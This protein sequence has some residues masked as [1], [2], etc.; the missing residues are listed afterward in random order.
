MRISTRP[1]NNPQRP[2]SA[3]RL[4]DRFARMRLELLESR[5][6]PTAGYLRIVTYNTAN[7]VSG[8]TS[9]DFGPRAG[10]GDVLGAIGVEKV[11]G[12]AR[13]IDILALQE[14]VYY[15]GTGIN[16][17]AQGFVTLLNSIYGTNALC[18]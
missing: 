16:P 6:L 17:T 12:I 13:P 8:S 3:R 9:I 10:M 11:A 14:S 7:D 4:S 2:Q 5:D 18:R 1:K 15:S